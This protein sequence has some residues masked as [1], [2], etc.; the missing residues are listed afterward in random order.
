MAIKRTTQRQNLVRPS[1]IV[2]DSGGLA[3]AQASQNIAN[4]ITNI[5][6]TVDKSQLQSAIIEAE[7]QGKQIGTRVD[8]NGVPIPLDMVTLNSFTTPIYNK[9]N[10]KT[11]QQYFKQQAINSYG[12]AIQNDAVKNAEN[13]LLNNRGKVGDDGKLLVETAGKGY[14]NS[15]KANV[16]NEV[17]NAI[18]PGLNKIWGGAS[19]KASAYMLDNARKINMANATSSLEH[20]LEYETNFITNGQADETEYE[21]ITSTKEKAFKLIEDN[22]D[23]SIEADTI[24]RTYATNLQGR[25]STNA[26][27]LGH[28][29]GMTTGDLLKMAKETSDAFL[30]DKNVDSNIVYKSMLNEIARLDKIDNANKQTLKNNSIIKSNEILLALQTENKYPSEEEVNKLEL[31]DQI[32]INN[33]VSAKLKQTTTN[34]EK[35]FNDAIDKTILSIKL[36]QINVVEQAGTDDDSDFTKDD[37][38]WLKKRKKHL[39]VNDLVSLLPNKLMKDDTAKKIYKLTEDIKNNYAKERSD[40]FKANISLAMSGNG[41]FTLIPSQLRS[42]KYIED[43]INQDL[44]GTKSYHAFTRDGWINEVNRYEKDYIKN[45]QEAKVLDNIGYKVENNIPLNNSEKAVIDKL[46]PTSFPYNGKPTEIDLLNEN[47][48]VRDESLKITTAYSLS[49]NNIHPKLKDLFD[50]IRSFA[51]NDQHFLYAKM[52]YFSLK[53]AFFDK[54]KNQNVNNRE[55]EDQWYQ[56]TSRKSNDLNISL[57]DD[58]RFYDDASRFASENSHVNAKRNLSEM[59]PQLAESGSTD[60]DIVVDGI[61]EVLEYSDNWFGWFGNVDGKEEENRSIRA[62]LDQQGFGNFS[63]AVINQPDIINQIIRGVKTRVRNNEVNMQYPKK[64]LLSAIKS[65]FY[66]LTG[67]VSLHTDKNGF[68]HLIEGTNI[69]KYAQM[70]VPG[71]AVTITKQDLIKD[72]LKDYNVSFGGGTQNQYILDAI[73]RED[74]MF[75]PNKE[76][77]GSQTYRVVAFAEDGNNLTLAENYTWDWSNSQVNADYKDALKKI[78][79]GGVRKLLSSLNFMS[80]NNLDAVMES[81]KSNREQAETWTNFIILYNK[82]AY[83]VNNLPRSPSNILPIINY[84]KSKEGQKELE[85]Y[86]DDKRYLRFDLR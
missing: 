73:D 48:D 72:V 86:F 60:R 84:V 14:L 45:Q 8:G 13:S 22:S 59:F 1:N 61:K 41:N 10:L 27:T 68:V 15:I 40:I 50:N 66:D 38:N 58:T 74:I 4:A 33:A 85:E 34:N 63:D 55:A 69:V 28:A 2:P 82:I 26:V 57:L 71:N 30:N 67:N 24:K 35:L 64:A 17:W 53:Q 16:D 6:E 79:N 62:W 11:A 9:A 51:G 65:E 70:Q 37:I 76:A 52:A 36:D 12:L 7:K 81:I 5:T 29:S 20:I 44:I 3:M 49:T 32:K 18:S 31:S 54:L 39:M 83:G 43:L 80:K 46:A 19:R 78:S 25:V 21:Y 77:A 75:I 56:Y 23:T 42:N 47:E